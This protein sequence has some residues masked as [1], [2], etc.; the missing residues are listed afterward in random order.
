MTAKYEKNLENYLKEAFKSYEKINSDKNLKFKA[1][2]AAQLLQA[3]GESMEYFRREMN[4]IFME[5]NYLETED[6]EKR[7]S[8][9]KGES[10][11]MVSAYRRLLDYDIKF[12]IL[13]RFTC[14]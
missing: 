7:F 12:F 8:E 2:V 14:R 11:Q 9:I 3:K 13:A 10:L 1:E 4:K 5:C 6:L